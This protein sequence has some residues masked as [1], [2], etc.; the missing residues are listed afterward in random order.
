MSIA[1]GQIWGT[2]RRA[3]VSNLP[4]GEWKTEAVFPFCSPRDFFGWP[5]P[6]ARAARADKCNVFMNQAGSV[7]GIRGG[8][9]FR[10]EGT[11][12][13]P[14]FEIQGDCVLHRG[15]CEDKEGWACFGEYFMNPQRGPVRIYRL[16]PTL[17]EQLGGRL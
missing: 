13:L 6:L 7:L 16:G 17:A 9:A 3:I 5:R 11:S 15:I 4:S 1:R 12:L 2:R 8:R 10:L 14:L